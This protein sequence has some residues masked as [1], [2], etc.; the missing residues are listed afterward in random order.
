MPQRFS[1][2]QTW[3]I[4]TCHI[5][6]AP[7]LAI[8][9]TKSGYWTALLLSDFCKVFPPAT[10][11]ILSLSRASQAL[12]MLIEEDRNL[13]NRQIGARDPLASYKRF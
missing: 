8:E 7:V 4:P 2:N 10:V 5:S 6:S 3:T 13:G 11:L 12:K 1:L 9:S